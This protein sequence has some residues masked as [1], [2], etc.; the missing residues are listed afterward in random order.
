MA[1]QAG[2]QGRVCRCGSAGD[3]EVETS[4]RLNADKYLQNVCA[5]VADAA[6]A[7]VCMIESVEKPL[8]MIRC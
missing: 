8:Y 7:S 3:V 1:R 5:V 6:D 4:V 2:V